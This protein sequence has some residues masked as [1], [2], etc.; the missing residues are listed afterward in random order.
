MHEVEQPLHVL[1]LHTL[2]VDQRV[3]MFVILQHLLKEGTAC[4]EHHLVSIELP[5]LTRQGYVAEEFI[6]PQTRECFRGILPMVVP[7]QEE[8]ASF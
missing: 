8:L 1:D 3:G 4:S 5:I 2:E 6:F 7:G